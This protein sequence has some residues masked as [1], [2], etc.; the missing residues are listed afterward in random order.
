MIVGNQYHLTYC[1]NIHPGQDWKSTFASLKAHVPEIMSSLGRNTAFGLGLRLSNRASEE[2]AEGKNLPEFKN[3]L[4]ANHIYVFT[5][6]G[7]PYGN[8]HGETVKDKVYLPDW[9][10][11]DRLS[12][13][14]RLFEQ[15]A[16]LLPDGI[17]G[18]IST[19]PISYK[20]WHNDQNTRKNTFI[21]AVGNLVRIT[22]FLRELEETKGHYMHLDLEPEPDCFLENTADVFNF[23]ENY[24]LPLGS[25]MLVEQLSVSKEQ[26]EQLLLRYICIC[27]D[28]CHFSLAYE[29][30]AYTFSHWARLGINVGKIQISAAL[31]ILATDPMEPLWEDLSR[32]NEPTYLHQVTQIADGEFRS[33]PDL[34]VVLE[35]KPEFK[36]LRAHYHVPVFLEKFGSLY[37]TQDHIRKVFACL[38]DHKLCNHL[39]I[40]TYT[41]DVL[42]ENLK[43]EI[44]SSIVREYKWV[45]DRL[46]Q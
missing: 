38:G 14:L 31:K 32:F 21:A 6:N 13:T 7:F 19:S 39:E 12:Y 35:T 22:V 36:E 2:L 4:E 18:G 5:M 1:T 3:W 23:Y 30:P 9:T 44:N 28:I 42:P 26:A 10:S 16:Y 8:F 25:E 34:P 43:T 46:E 45:L 11:P 17:D 20:R 27:Y 15:L 24:L 41:W 40:E 37:S 29:D 33:F